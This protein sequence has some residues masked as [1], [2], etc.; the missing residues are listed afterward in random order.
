ME[1]KSN[2]LDRLYY[3]HKDEYDRKAIEVLESGW[4]VL[5]KQVTEFEKEFSNY[6]GADYCVG[7]ASGLDALILAFRALGIGKGDKVIAPANTYIA[8]IMGVTINGAEPQFVEP[9]EYYNIDYSKIEE[10]I[11]EETKAILVVHLYGQAARMDKIMDIAKKYDLYV[12]E[13]CAQ[14]HGAEVAGK[15]VGS[16]GEIGCWSF[17]PS[18]NVGAFGDAGAITTDSEKI[19]NDIKVLRNYGSEKKYYNKVIGYN[20]RLDEMQA[21]LLRIKLKYANEIIE[22]KTKIANFYLENIKNNKIILPGV[23]NGAKHVWHQFVIRTENRDEFKKYM[24]KNGIGTD[25]HYPIPPH[26]AEAY[27]NLK[28]KTGDFEITEKYA[29][30][31][32]SIPTY[33]GMTDEEMQYIVDVINRY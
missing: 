2:V 27:K 13:D 5:G 8:S 29:K 25:I 24:F 30:E 26:L 14:A 28:Y 21:G 18:K 16:F 22:E 20:S 33:N 1:I 32:L 19:A 9:D 6:I 4:Y 7:V 17:Y 11:T 31:V 12:V 10:A 15:K 23:C 3:R